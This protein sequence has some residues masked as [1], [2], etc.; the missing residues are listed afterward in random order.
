MYL[1]DDIHK[2]VAYHNTGPDQIPGLIVMTVSDGICAGESL[3]TDLD[4]IVI[5]FNGTPEE[6]S[7]DTEVYGLQ[8][9]TEI[10]K[11]VD[12]GLGSEEV[13]GSRATVPAISAVVFVK[14]SLNRQGEFPCIIH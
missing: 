8:S 7:F 1:A 10:M 6:R 13:T 14:P 2:R 5:L 11:S 3:D 12:E 4:G 9:H